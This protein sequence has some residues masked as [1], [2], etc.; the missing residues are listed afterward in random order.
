MSPMAVSYE[1]PAVARRRPTDHIENARRRRGAPVLTAAVAIAVGAVAFK[2]GGYAIGVR[3][4]AAIAI[5]WTVALGVA[6]GLWPR[7]PIP[8]P[9]LAAGGALAALAL[10]AAVSALWG[11]SSEAAFEEAGRTVAYLGVLAIVVLVA[12]PGTAV[13]WTDGLAAGI[14]G[15]GLVALSGRLFPGLGIDESVSRYFAGDVYLSYPLGYWNALAAFIGLSFPLLL[16]TCLDARSTA[17][18]LLAMAALPALAGAVFLT[19]SR[20]GMLAAGVATAVFVALAADRVRAAA[21]AA[22]M[23]AGA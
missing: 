18:R 22:V 2:G 1:V 13:R 12:R 10:L 4:P 15:V 6:L 16:R 17:A 19:S 3:N 14:A 23:S 8:R 20:G 21:A 11:A 9:A 5:W 7:T